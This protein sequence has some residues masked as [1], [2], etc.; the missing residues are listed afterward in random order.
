MILGQ[1]ILRLLTV[2]ALLGRTWAGT[3]V[4]DSPAK[5]ADLTIEQERAAF[6][7]VYTDEAD[8]DLD[9]QSFWNPDATVYLLIEC[10]TADRI[11]VPG[12]PNGSGPTEPPA[13]ETTITLSQTDQALELVIGMLARQVVQALLAT[14]QNNPWAELWRLFTSP[15]RSRVEVRR[16]GPGQEGQQSAIRYASRIMRMSLKV[17]ADPVYGEG[18]PKGFWTRFFEV[19]E[20][21]TQDLAHIVPIIKAHFETEPGVLSWRVEQM[22]GTYTTP[23]L[24]STGITPVEERLREG[25]R[26]TKRG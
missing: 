10:A 14:D 13:G 8:H 4:F 6:L 26:A 19:A 1:D 7:G 5:P 15:G 12:K 18:I 2:K 20:A 23:G 9:G 25:W 17:I 22:R 21:D 11:T 16:G 3:R 24:H